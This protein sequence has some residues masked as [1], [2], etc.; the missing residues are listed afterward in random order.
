MCRHGGFQIQQ[1]NKLRDIVASL[2]DEVCSNV[3]TEPQLQALSGEH[4]PRS[5]NKEDNA[6]LDVRASGFWGVGEKDAFF[7]IRVFYPF[8]SSY[9]SSRLTALYMQQENMKRGEYGERVRDVE[10]AYFT[11]L[12]FTF[13]GARLRKPLS[14]LNAL[15]AC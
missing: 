4:L 13:G 14:F 11:P 1:H 12:V 6:R 2:L 3:A 7:D 9:Q 5:A 10:D 8:A 15:P